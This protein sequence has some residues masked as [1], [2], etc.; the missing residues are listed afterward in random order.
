[1]EQPII[2]YGHPVCPYAHGVILTLLEKKEKFENVRVPRELEVEQALKAGSVAELR[3][4]KDSGKSPQDLKSIR[5]E[6]TTKINKSKKMPTILVKGLY[7]LE[8]EII[9]EFIDKYSSNIEVQ[10]S[11]SK[12][13][14]IA[15]TRLLF[16]NIYPSLIENLYGLLKNFDTTKDSEFAK[17]IY[18]VLQN[19]VMHIESPYFLGESVSLVDVNVYPF[20]LRFIPVL[21]HYRNFEMIPTDQAKYPWASKLTNYLDQLSKFESVKS[22]TLSEEIYVEE[23]IGFAKEIRKIDYQI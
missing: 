1:M 3:F 5:E 21:K 22:S 16:K 4:F 23:Y 14:D 15:K 12:P 10:L 20:L 17:N 2:F 9:S 6:Y 8:S 13:F 19:F 11:P 7:I 18:Y